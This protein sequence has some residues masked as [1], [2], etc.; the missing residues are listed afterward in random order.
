[1]SHA[2]VDIVIITGMSG[3][4]KTV[5]VQSFEDLG[6]YC[7]D[8]LP[9]ALL[10]KFVELIEVGA[11]RVTKIAL[12]MDLRG[13]SFFDELFQ[14]LDELSASAPAWLRMQI[15]FLDAKDAALVQRYKETRRTHP[16]AMDGL[17]LE[18][19]QK[20]RQL[21]EEMKGRAQQIVDTTD[22]KPRALREKIQKRFGTKE[23]PVFTVHFLSF[24]FKYGI[25]IDADLVFDVRFLPNPHYIAEL[26]PKTGLEQEV[27]SYVLKWQDTQQFV[28]KLTDL[29]SFMLPHY[30]REGKSQVVIAIG[31]TG[32]QHRSVTL[33]EHFGAY[34]EEAWRTYVSHRDISKRK[35]QLS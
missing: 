29:F 31:C 21:L 25:P 16:L 33:A 10:G 1:M 34:F 23:R 3:A 17:L 26:Q 13:Q 15:L 28:H 6:F 27:S 12:V 30:K 20:E 14:A 5:A 4:G 32:G 2:D 11:D 22:L 8:N 7:V 19:I 9:P 24:G 35:A 18:G